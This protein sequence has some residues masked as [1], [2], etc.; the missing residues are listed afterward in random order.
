MEVMSVH[1]KLVEDKETLVRL[2]QYE[3]AFYL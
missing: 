2:C 3:K 1:W